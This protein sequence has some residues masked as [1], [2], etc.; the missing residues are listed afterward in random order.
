VAGTDLDIAVV[1][2]GA[3]GLVA[4]IFAGRA[5]KEAGRELRIAAL[6]GAKK[7]GAKILVAGGGRCNVTHDV[8][9]PEDFFG[10]NRNQVAKVLRSLDVPATVEFFRELGVELKREPTGKLFPTTDRAQTVLDALIRATEEAGASILTEHRVLHLTREGDAFRMKLWDKEITAARL[11]L[12]TGGKSLP[13]TGSDGLGYELAKLLGHTVTRTTPALVPLVLPDGHWLTK[14]SGVSL[15]AELILAAASGKV[16]RRERGSMLFTH[17]GLSGPLVLDMSRHWIA[18][19]ADGGVAAPKLACSFLPGH[20]FAEAD[21]TLLLAARERPRATVGAT[22]RTW[23]PARLA[24]AL[25]VEAAQVAPDTLM[26]KLTKEQRR[27]VVH[28]L[29]ALPL[30]VV[31]DRGYLFAEVTAGGVPLSEVDVSTMASRVCPG[32]YLC[33]EILDV[34][35][36]IGGYNFQWAWASGRLAGMAAALAGSP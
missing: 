20:E 14:L 28:T 5:A 24:E 3:A 19:V 29:T 25:A 8:V 18:A 30:P 35:G 23:L 6:D 34:D 16:L 2:A 1:G 27:A 11:I 17:F 36:R 7:L 32:L 13:R 33:G 22:L 4:A 21:E 26:S 15:E 10:G 12:A 31:R 9:K